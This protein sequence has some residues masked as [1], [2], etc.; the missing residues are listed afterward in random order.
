MKFKTM[1]KKDWVIL[2]LLLLALDSNRHNSPDVI[3]T[4]LYMSRKHGLNTLE[5]AAELIRG[6]K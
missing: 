4:V 1:T 5:R 3:N 2:R 6:G